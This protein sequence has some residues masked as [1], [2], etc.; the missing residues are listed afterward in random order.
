MGHMLHHWNQLGTITLHQ[1]PSRLTYTLCSG[2]AGILFLAIPDQI[3][4]HSRNTWLWLHVSVGFAQEVSAIPAHLSP[5]RAELLQLH[6]P[7]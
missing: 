1:C 4:H 2:S 6:S 7:L 5:G 3:K